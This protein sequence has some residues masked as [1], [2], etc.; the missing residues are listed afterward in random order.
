MCAGDAVRRGTLKGYTWFEQKGDPKF[1]IMLK[2]DIKCYEEEAKSCDAAILQ[3]FI[4]YWKAVEKYLAEGQGEFEKMAEKIMAP[5]VELSD[6]H[7]L[8]G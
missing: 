4:A 1:P 7:R 5:N 3:H 6:G 8:E 2:Q